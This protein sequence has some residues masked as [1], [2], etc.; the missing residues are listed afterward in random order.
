MESKNNQPLIDFFRYNISD[1]EDSFDQGHS[2]QGADELL[3][4]EDGGDELEELELPSDNGF[5]GGLDE[6][7]N[8][9][10]EILKGS[11]GHR[12]DVPK[13][14]CSLPSN[15]DKPHCTFKRKPRH[16]SKRSPS[17]TNRALSPLGYTQFYLPSMMKQKKRPKWEVEYTTYKVKTLVPSSP[18]NTTQPLPVPL[19]LLPGYDPSVFS[20]PKNKTEEKEVAKKTAKF[21]KAVKAVTPYR[22]K[23]LTIGS[24]VKLARMLVLEK[25][26]WKKFAELM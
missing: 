22:M 7:E 16:Y 4:D 13:G 11:G 18:E 20:K 8:E 3:D 6:R 1:E 21:Y 14:D 12:H 2:Y 15:E 5:F 25:K 24:W 23:D 10:I 26:R 17:R 9:D 19:H